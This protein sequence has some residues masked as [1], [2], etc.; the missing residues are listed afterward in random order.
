MSSSATH[1]AVAGG[2]PSP[3][4]R[5][6]RT[7]EQWVHAFAEGWRDRSE[8]GQ[9][10]AEAFIAH[11]REMLDEDVRLIQPQLGTL[12]GRRAFEE[13]FARPLFDLIPDLRADVERWAVNGDDAFIEI[14]LRGTLAGR[15]VAWRA[16][17]R[18]TVRDGVA[19]ERESYLDPAPLLAAIAR[20]PRLW[21]RFIRLQINARL[22]TRK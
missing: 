20:A 4:G 8:I 22:R 3:E 16:C 6:V 13:G 18:I 17:D 12:V 9:R 7:P 21:P 11:F 2:Q 10:G 14:T 5:G 15:A 19:I 1:D